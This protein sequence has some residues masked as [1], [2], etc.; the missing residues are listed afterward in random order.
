[1]NNDYICCFTG[2][3][4]IPDK[5]MIHLPVLLEK[6]I[7]EQCQK[8]ARIFRTGGAI[9]FDSIAALKVIHLKN[10]F[11]DVKLE[12]CLPCRDQSDKWSEYSRSVYNY[13]LRNCDRVRYAADSYIP[14]CMHTRNR[15]LVDGADVCIAYYMGG[16]GGTAYTVSYAL[17]NRLEFINLFDCFKKRT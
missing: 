5:H 2:H 3:R 9:G 13:I 14:G 7:R 17:K 6:T 1:M 12:L 11:P 16:N 8:G 4:D 15:M 10:E